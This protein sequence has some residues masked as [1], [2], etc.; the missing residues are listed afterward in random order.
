MAKISDLPD[1]YPAPTAPAGG[2]AVGSV[3][4]FVCGRTA[5]EKRARTGFLFIAPSLFFVMLLF[6]IPMG[7]NVYLSAVKYHIARPAAFV[8]LG[9]YRSVLA[10]DDFW[11]SLIHTL[12]FTA[13]SVPVTVAL[14]LV[15]ALAFHR[16]GTR[17]G[18]SL[19]RALYF[20]PVVASLTAVAYIWA[21]IFNPAYGLANNVLTILSLPTAKWLNSTRQVI[22]SLS[23]MYVWARLGFNMLILLAGLNAIDRDYYE[24]AEIDG[25]TAWGAFRNITLPLLNRQLVLVSV[26]EVMT[27]LK[28]FAL[29][30]AATGGGPVNA[31]RTLVMTIYQWA[32]QWNRIGESAVASLFLFV[33]IL[34]LT[35]LQQRTF[36]RREGC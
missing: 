35:L 3:H 23:I 32:F 10:N 12:H 18:T 19:V 34:L 2:V 11:E 6:V 29:P 14:A 36:A 16:I 9:N 17:A 24:A 21:W 33:L 31:S 22:P 28:V 4:D 8:G 30:Y 13:I 20:V 15:V 26:V 7:Y 25:A 1:G 27:A 5:T